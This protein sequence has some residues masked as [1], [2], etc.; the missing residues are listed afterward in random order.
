VK[1][2]LEISAIV[3]AFNAEKFLG[4]ALRSALTQNHSP[5]EVIVVDDG[6]TDATAEIA[7][8][9]GKPVRCIRQ[10]RAGVSAARNRGIEAAAGDLVAFLDADDEWL[11]HHL[12]RASN[13]FR[14]HAELHWYGSASERRERSGW[15]ERCGGDPRQLTD[16]AYFENYFEAARRWTNYT[17][18]MVLRKALF[19]D[20]G[21]FDV[22]MQTAEDLDMWFRIGLAHPRIGYCNEVGVIIWE[23]EGSLARRG[24]FTLEAAKRFVAKCEA[25]AE[26]FGRSREE[27]V[28]RYLVQRMVDVVRGALLRRDRELLGWLTEH[29]GT[30]LPYRWRLRSRLCRLTPEPLWSFAVKSWETS[31]PLRRKWQQ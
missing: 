10:K 7:S 23:T 6:S 15:V 12:E 21:T 29:F 19:A 14:A 24:L 18:A 11:P 28:R 25:G 13:V 2:S 5:F 16:G 26:A 17:P 31:R 4:R 8:A 20:V 1:G 30:E 9:F 3:P 22:E 27:A